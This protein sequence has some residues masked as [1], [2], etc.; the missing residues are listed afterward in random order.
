MAVVG[1]MPKIKRCAKTA[2]KR[3]VTVSAQKLLLEHSD[4]RPVQVEKVKVE[5]LE[6]VHLDFSLI[7]AW[8]SGT[9][10]GETE[11]ALSVDLLCLQ[12]G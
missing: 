4:L 3:I 2:K 10:A 8:C 9:C 7:S 6:K 11:K 5:I 1:K 12:T